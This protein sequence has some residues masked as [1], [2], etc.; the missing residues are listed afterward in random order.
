MNGNG[1][2]SNILMVLQDSRRASICNEFQSVLAK[3]SLKPTFRWL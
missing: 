1:A 3:L 2:T